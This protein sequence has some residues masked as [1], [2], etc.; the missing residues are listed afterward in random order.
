MSDTST[1]LLAVAAVAAVAVAV[2]AE[3]SGVRALLSNDY[4]YRAGDLTLDEFQ[5]PKTFFSS[6]TQT[7]S[8]F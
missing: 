6:F 2:D 1:V 7:A 5:R 8:R 3:W 4:G